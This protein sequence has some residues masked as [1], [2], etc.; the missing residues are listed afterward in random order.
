MKSAFALI[1]LLV[2][3]VAL[4]G[5]FTS[6]LSNRPMVLKLG[7]VPDAQALKIFAGDQRYLIADYLVTRVLF[8]FGTYM[9]RDRRVV[10]DK[11]EYLNMFKTLETA[12]KLDPYNIDAYYFTQAAFTWEL[13]RAKDVNKVLAYG[14]KY[15]TWDYQLPFY[16]G[17]NA[18][19]FL[20]DYKSAANYMRKAAEL[21]GEQLF[22]NLA[23][24]YFYEADESDLGIIFLDTMTRG[25]RDP[26]VKNVYKLRR[27]ALDAVKIIEQALDSYRLKTGER[28]P[29]SLEELVTIGILNA[30][31]ADPYGGTFY[32][33]DKGKVRSTSRFSL[34]TPVES[35]KKS[36]GETR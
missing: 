23:A 15:R 2:S 16:A 5:P 14:M 8:Y 25:A 21:S 1:V 18:A 26:Q 24:R 4:L 6:Y 10:M 17:F 33:D 20:K 3:Y 11:P 29:G 7:S 35:L 30:L 28:M 32:L 12:V 19:Y 13:G 22:T 34:T 9:D 27:E 36:D 31:P